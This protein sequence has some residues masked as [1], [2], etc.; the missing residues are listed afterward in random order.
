MVQKL[1]LHKQTDRRTICKIVQSKRGQL[2]L[3]PFQCALSHSQYTDVVNV[4]LDLM[5]VMNVTTG[6]WSQNDTISN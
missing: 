5:T 1:F 6:R 3:T 2:G 4:I